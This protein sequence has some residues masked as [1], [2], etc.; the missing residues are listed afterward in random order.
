MDNEVG[1]INVKQDPPQLRLKIWRVRNNKSQVEFGKEIGTA[2]PNV[3][4]YENK[5]RRPSPE[6]AQAIERVTGIPWTAWFEDVD[7]AEPL[8]SAEVEEEPGST[9]A[10]S[11]EVEKVE[12]EAS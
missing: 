9:F 2:G 7:P 1:Q 4:D 11:E 10:T 3:S 12:Q 5:K 8:P 6:T